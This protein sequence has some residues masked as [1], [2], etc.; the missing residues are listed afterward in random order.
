MDFER[1]PANNRTEFGN[2]L[3]DD[4]SE[5]FITHLEVSHDGSALVDSCSVKIYLLNVPRASLIRTS[6]LSGASA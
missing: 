6:I 3:L 1:E 4:L 2:F 5:G